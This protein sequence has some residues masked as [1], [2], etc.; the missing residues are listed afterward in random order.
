MFSLKNPGTPC[1]VK[2]FF[3]GEPQRN[4][5][6]T[7]AESRTISLDA[8][9]PSHARTLQ[10]AL[11]RAHVG[12]CGYSATVS[13]SNA[14]AS[15]F[16]V[17]AG[18]IVLSERILS[19]PSVLSLHW[20]HAVELT[21]WSQLCSFERDSVYATA[22]ALLAGLT[23]TRFYLQM[24]TDEQ[25][26]VAPRMPPWLIESAE[27]A[28]RFSA[29]EVLQTLALHLNSL[30]ILQGS[31]PQS[32]AL[33]NDAL[34]LAIQYSPVAN[35]T[36]YTLT[37]Q[38]DER[39]LIN[40]Q[41]G[42]NKYG[43]SP[44]PR[45]EAITF[46][47]CTASSV[48]EYAY[49]ESELLRH[50][51]MKTLMQGNLAAQYEIEIEGVRS[52]LE[53]LLGLAALRLETFLSSSGTDAE[54]Y[55][56]AFLR[57]LGKRKVINIVVAP[58][59][60]GSGTVQAAGGRHFS[61]K[62]PLGRKAQPGGAI[63]DLDAE[64]IEV[65]CIGVRETCGANLAQEELKERIAGAVAEAIKRADSVILHIVDNTKTG[66]VVPEVDFVQSLQETFGAKLV[67]VVDA[68]QF[69][70]EKSNLH[71]Y[72]SLGFCV[73]ITGSK[74]FTGP[75]FCGALLVPSQFDVRGNDAALPQGFEDYFTRAEVPNS[76][77]SRAQSLS[78]ALN[79]GL[80]FRWAGALKE[81]DSFYSVPGPER[82]SILD[83][84]RSE[85]M[86]SIRE[87]PDLQLLE[88]P[89]PYRW[90]DADG[91]L[92]D[93]GPTIFSF[94]VKSPNDLD[95]WLPVRA[96]KTI[97]Y[98]LN[99]DCSAHLPESASDAERQLAAQKC[100]IG[101]PV[102]IR[103]CSQDGEIGALRIACGARLVYGITYDSTLGR[104]ASE[105]FQRELNDARTV[106]AKISLVLKYWN[107]LCDEPL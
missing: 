97:Y 77:R 8:V 21:L 78:S 40:P 33:A 23:T 5:L 18:K 53:E 9:S 70:L 92:W 80:L 102:T 10:S 19:D 81:I 41:T 58:D 83:R 100:H 79:L 42:L 103:R 46:S 35:P 12:L 71:R 16:E 44:R 17:H 27:A 45:P 86:N 98:L 59:E 107:A 54:L 105:R 22:V 65:V 62:T 60:V 66:M 38:G 69:R 34:R 20:R 31:R 52:G 55:P 15:D 24:L 96:L 84:F 13:T 67:V 63:A 95:K 36:E 56:L 57:A 101:Q 50:R 25:Q 74:F 91:A 88:P 99:R 4:P 11:A 29:E 26:R 51:L 90:Q 30:T 93:A 48:S 75:P 76:I 87:N 2:Q 3:T 39:L 28:E 104:K 61:L 64:S 43:C 49:R 94:A 73:L 89:H 72:L 82:T 32:P 1:D 85:L 14:L 7:L 106:L 68:C 47:S 6:L 37:Q